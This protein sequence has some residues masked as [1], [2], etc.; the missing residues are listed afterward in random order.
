MKGHRSD[1]LI[2][3]FIPT[4]EVM[5]WGFHF[6]AVFVAIIAFSCYNNLRLKIAFNDFDRISCGGS[7]ARRSENILSLN[8]FA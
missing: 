1:V 7:A 2:E 4:A 3:H 5:L 8:P 6:S